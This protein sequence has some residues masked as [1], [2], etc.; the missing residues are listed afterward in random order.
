MSKGWE[1]DMTKLVRKLGRGQWDLSDFDH[2]LFVGA[3]WADFE[4][5]R[6]CC[7]RASRVY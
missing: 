3:R 4:Y 5:F 1:L 2:G 7:A 6:S